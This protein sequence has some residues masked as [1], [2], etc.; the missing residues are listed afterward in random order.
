MLEFWKLLELGSGE[1]VSDS[2]LGSLEGKAGGGGGG[3]ECILAFCTVEIK[4]VIK[5][6]SA[7]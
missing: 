5:F 1:P 4:N 2:L 6:Q 7:T 3:M